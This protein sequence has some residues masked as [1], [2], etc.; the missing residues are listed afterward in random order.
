M[1][2]KGKKR[3]MTLSRKK[4]RW[5][6][7]FVL[8]LIFGLIFQFGVPTLRS[9]WFAFCEVTAKG[10]EGFKAVFNAGQNFYDAVL[11]NTT[12]R[13][14]AV[15]SL[16][17][18]LLNLPLITIFSFFA[19][20]LLN[21][22]F[23]GRWLVRVIFF[24]PLILAAPSLMNFDA[25]DALQSLMGSSGNFKSSES[26]GGLTTVNLANL[27]ISSGILTQTVAQYLISAAD[28]IYNIVILSG[29]QI[30]VFL[31]ALQAIPPTMYEVAAIEGASAWES[32]WRI[33][34]PMTCPMIMTCMIYT[35]IDSFTSSTNE[36]LEMIE[37]T[38][39]STFR[40][41]LSAAM[42]WIYTALILLMLGIVVLVMRK[43]V[44]QYE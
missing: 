32:Y 7:L 21:Q 43:V 42:S 38:A 41:G 19:A 39:F 30:L 9:L 15:E 36:T 10:T 40:Y 11:V 44:K 17:A 14:K 26:L 5:G 23:H 3:M 16:L 33:T 1:R 35:I 37:N 12:F 4:A 8:P 34:F 27:L 29:V 24:M 6:Y 20:S 2:K 18:V 25:G 31:A 22:K 28:R 13:E